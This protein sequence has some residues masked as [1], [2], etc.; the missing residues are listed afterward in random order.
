[1]WGGRGA[2]STLP[3]SCSFSWDFNR[4]MHISGDFLEPEGLGRGTV[5][6]C[7]P[8]CCGP[9]LH[10]EPGTATRAHKGTSSKYWQPKEHCFIIILYLLLRLW[11]NEGQSSLALLTVCGGRGWV[12][13]D[14]YPVLHPKLC[15]LP[16]APSN[17]A[18]EWFINAKWLTRQVY[19]IFQ[20]SIYGQAWCASQFCWEGKWKINKTLFTADCPSWSHL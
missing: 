14:V 16:R 10:H 18:P 2:V 9:T 3:R 15:N 12:R 6:P 7:L 13:R 8:A 17:G 11:V 20:I 4:P 1:M 5:L 19:N